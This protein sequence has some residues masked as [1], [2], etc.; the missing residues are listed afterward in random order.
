MTKVFCKN[1]CGFAD[2]FERDDFG[3]NYYQAIGTCPNCD[4][5]TVYEDGTETAI[6]VE[7]Q[8]VKEAA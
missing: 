7:F 1:E 3:V 6:V 5:P 4:A 2:E 8:V